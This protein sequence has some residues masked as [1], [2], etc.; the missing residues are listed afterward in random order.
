[1]VLILMVLL[2]SFLIA[3][4]LYLMNILHVILIY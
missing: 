3:G 1:M 2:L 4:Y